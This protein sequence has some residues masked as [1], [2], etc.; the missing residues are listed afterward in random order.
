LRQDLTWFPIEEDNSYIA[1]SF[2]SK[3]VV[4]I[5]FQNYREEPNLVH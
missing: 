3:F 1:L 5:E 4:I 2:F